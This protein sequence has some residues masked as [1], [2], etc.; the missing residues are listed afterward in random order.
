LSNIEEK[1]PASIE[2]LHGTHPFLWSRSKF[3]NLCKVD[4]IVNNLSELFN[5]WVLKTKD[6]Q[7]VDMLK[8]IRKMIVTKFDERSRIARKMEG[9]I[10]PSITKDLTA[11]SKDIK[12]HEVLRCV[13]GTA[14]VIVSTITHA[15]NL[16]QK[17]L[18]L[19]SM[20]SKWEAL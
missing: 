14:E 4:Y 15:V 11:Q 7:V 10:I 9:G 3:S 20:A 5:S 19:S 1:C 13:D 2:W 17:N 18:Y 16:E 8:N 12:N 6:I